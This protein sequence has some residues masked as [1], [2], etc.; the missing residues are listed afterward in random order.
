MIEQLQCRIDKIEAQLSQCQAEATASNDL[1]TGLVLQ[2]ALRQDQQSSQS[3][4]ADSTP[5]PSLGESLASVLPKNS[6]FQQNRTVLDR[7]KYN[8]APGMLKQTGVDRLEME[9]G[10]SMWQDLDS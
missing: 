7:S 5:D 9:I 2:L 6:T 3:C 4:S 1:T 10:Q 8:Y